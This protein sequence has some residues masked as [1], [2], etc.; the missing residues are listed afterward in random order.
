MCSR[1]K[2]CCKACREELSLKMSSIKNHIHSAKHEEGVKKM[3][4]KELRERSI[5]ESTALAKGL[6]V[7]PSSAVSECIFHL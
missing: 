5:A 4:S 7:Q 3:Q 6:L 1:N 2:L